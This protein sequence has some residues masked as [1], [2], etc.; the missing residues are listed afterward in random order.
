MTNAFNVC[1]ELSQVL[2][3]KRGLGVQRKHLLL[4]DINTNNS[5]LDVIEMI[6]TTEL[7]HGFFHK[8]D[9]GT[10]IE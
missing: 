2:N 9:M 1:E 3:L 4:I 10:L 6:L 8:L 7:L 5:M